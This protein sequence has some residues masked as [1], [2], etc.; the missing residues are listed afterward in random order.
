MHWSWWFL[1]SLPGTQEC[2]ALKLIDKNF[3]IENSKQST[4]LNERNIMASLNNR[5]VVH[6]HYAF[7]SKFYLVFVQEYCAGGEIFYH[8]RRF[9]Q[10]TED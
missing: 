3:I 8:L 1:K 10:L 7:E 6:L 9:K 4:V 2:Y 5:F